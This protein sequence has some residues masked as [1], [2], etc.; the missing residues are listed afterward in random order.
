[1]IE[2][3]PEELLTLCVRP[4]LGRM[5]DEDKRQR[6]QR[7]GRRIHL[8]EEEICLKNR[9]Q[10]SPI[11]AGSVVR[12]PF[13]DECAILRDWVGG[14]APV[15]ID[16]G[17]EEDLW[18]ILKGSANGPAYVAPFPR[19]QFVEIHRVGAT[20][21]VRDI[22]EKFV[23]DIAA[24]V[25]QHESNLALNR[26][27]QLTGSYR[28]LRGTRW[29]NALLRCN[30]QNGAFCFVSTARPIPP[31]LA[32]KPPGRPAISES[33]N[34]K[35]ESSSSHEAT[36]KWTVAVSQGKGSDSHHVP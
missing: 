28:L 29:S 9:D 26:T 15:F 2:I 20:E 17:G 35:R 14:S 22:F 6:D 10:L 36:D 7:D 27:G 18:W 1:M 16:F 33:L 21:E 30:S 4:R 19:G 13:S 31:A 24:L 8:T 5:I 11:G 12:V 3:R 23:N 25:S 32:E 34:R